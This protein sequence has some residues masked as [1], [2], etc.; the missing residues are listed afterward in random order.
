MSKK[1]RS[2]ISWL[3]LDNW[4]INF[5]FPKFSLSKFFPNSNLKMHKMYQAV[6][7][8]VARTIYVATC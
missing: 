6:A 8:M 7:Y 1:L 5:E 4:R 3:K 2:G